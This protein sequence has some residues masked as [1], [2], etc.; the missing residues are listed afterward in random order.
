[1][2][3]Q[4]LVGFVGL[5]LLIPALAVPAPADEGFQESIQP[6]LKRY[7]I[8]CHGNDHAE[9]DFNLEATAEGQS[10]PKVLSGIAS[11]DKVADRLRSQTMPPPDAEPLADPGDEDVAPRRIGV[12]I[13][14]AAV[15]A[16]VP[17]GEWARH[18]DTVTILDL[19]H[20][21]KRRRGLTLEDRFLGT[22]TPRLFT[23]PRAPARDRARASRT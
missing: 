23:P 15:A 6:L 4:F 9:D 2:Q 19:D 20:H 7:C 17:P 11:L 5:S 18:A 22:P 8:D 1:M 3:R 21:R 12:V 10:L 14:R 16:G 13:D